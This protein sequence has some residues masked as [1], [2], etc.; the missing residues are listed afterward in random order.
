MQTK[1]CIQPFN[2]IKLL[3]LLVVAEGAYVVALSD[4]LGEIE[5]ASVALA[6]AVVT[7]HS[8]VAKHSDLFIGA[9]CLLPS[10]Y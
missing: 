9:A 2:F 1:E 6:D 8:D 5:H 7:A 3:V 10:L 4:A